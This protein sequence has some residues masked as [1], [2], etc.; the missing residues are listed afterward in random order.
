MTLINNSKGRFLL[1]P[2]ER[3]TSSYGITW[4]RSKPIFFNT[5]ARYYD[6]RG[7]L[8]GWP[9]SRHGW[10]CFP[11]KGEGWHLWPFFSGKRALTGPPNDPLKT[12]NTVE[13][14]I[15]PEAGHSQDGV[16]TCLSRAKMT[17]FFI[18]I[19][20]IIAIFLRI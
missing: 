6:R 18:L 1:R 2:L 5:I 8:L 12:L 4:R 3:Q 17:A 10:F 19:N 7:F 9:V 16:K 15:I 13:R 14:V 11:I 20:N